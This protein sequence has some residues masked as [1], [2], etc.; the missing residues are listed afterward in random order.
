MISLQALYRFFLATSLAVLLA[1]TIAFGFNAGDSWARPLPASLI[2]L[3]Q[4]QIATMS[5]AKAITK[6]IEGKAQEVMGNVTS[7]PNDQMMGKA[8]QVES[9]NRNVE[10]AASQARNA[11]LDMKEKLKLKAK[12]KGS[13]KK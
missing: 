10:Q 4:L 6:N 1:T 2:S 3:T 11:A 12:S 13:D 8:K 7:T 5:Q 9:Q